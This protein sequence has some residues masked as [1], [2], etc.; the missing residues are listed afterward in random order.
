MNDMHSETHTNGA[1]GA[2]MPPFNPMP[3]SLDMA[4]IV[5]AQSTWLGVS[6]T[7]RD[8]AFKFCDSIAVNISTA[9]GDMRTD[10]LVS[11]GEAMDRVVKQFRILG[12]EFEV[13]AV[14]E[15]DTKPENMTLKQAAEELAKAEPVTEP[16]PVLESRVLIGRQA[17]ARLKEKMAA[18]VYA[19]DRETMVG[20][21]TTPTG[22]MM[23]SAFPK[24]DVRIVAFTSALDGLGVKYT[25]HDL[26]PGEAVVEPVEEPATKTPRGAARA[27]RRA[28]AS[29]DEDE[30][31][32]TSID[33]AIAHAMGEEFAA[34]LKIVLKA[35]PK[36][37]AGAAIQHVVLAS[38]PEQKRLELAAHDGNRY[39]LAF[40]PTSD[41]VTMAPQAIQLRNAR[42]LLKSVEYAVKE[43][44]LGARVGFAEHT[45]SPTRLII[46][47]GKPQALTFELKLAAKGEPEGWRPPKFSRAGDVT[48]AEHDARSIQD[49]TSWKG[50][51]VTRDERDGVG[52]RHITLM[53]QAGVE[54]MRAVIVPTGLTEGLPDEP[55]LE[56]DGTLSPKKRGKL[57][58]EPVATGPASKRAGTGS[59]LLQRSANGKDWS[60]EQSGS[61]SEIADAF[62]AAKK[63]RDGAWLR[64]FAPDG[65]Q[66]KYF[67]G[68][69][70]AMT[71]TE[72]RKAAGSAAKKPARKLETNVSARRPVKPAKTGR[73][74]K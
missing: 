10:P 38:D 39:H 15:S 21:S 37:G 48:E 54:L 49:A 32:D 74:K 25:V 50:A 43:R 9:T 57:K 8:A 63:K 4:R 35:A 3:P 12:I 24:G 66:V 17:W 69:A 31:N 42:S 1:G 7:A 40:V 52:R 11:G 60:T 65:L 47:C 6:Q 28:D 72:K 23:T 13:V 45:G 46:S 73:S 26:P 62:A 29:D 58:A 67:E 22:A 68:K 71:A 19:A 56:I 5:V 53:D 2:P 59:W 44:K 64:T 51:R 33:L 36:R 34:A 30:E 20:L 61:E 27:A 70:Q 16:V 14:G 55:Q 18:K 41:A